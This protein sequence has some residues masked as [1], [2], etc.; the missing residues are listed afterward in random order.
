MT[1]YIYNIY[2]GEELSAVHN[3]N[4]YYTYFIVTFTQFKGIDHMVCYLYL[5]FS[6]FSEVYFETLEHLSIVIKAYIYLS[7]QVN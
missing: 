6:D 4:H 2:C 1:C 7:F 5:T 3:Y